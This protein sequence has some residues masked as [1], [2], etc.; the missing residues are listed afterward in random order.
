VP[1][2]VSMFSFNTNWHVLVTV[3]HATATYSGSRIAV[4]LLIQM[5]NQTREKNIFTSIWYKCVSVWVLQKNL[6]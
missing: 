4:L 5:C 2:V 1:L 3:M 6:G